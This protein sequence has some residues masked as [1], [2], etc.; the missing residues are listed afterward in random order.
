MNRNEKHREIR[1]Y[2]LFFSVV[3][4]QLSAREIH[5][6]PLVNDTKTNTRRR[7]TRGIMRTMFLCTE[8]LNI[9]CSDLE[10]RGVFKLRHPKFPVRN[11][12]LIRL[13]KMKVC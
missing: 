11:E 5:E 6:T 4:L 2:S 3:Y 10:E 7:E 1:N 8:K 13:V 9:L 12:V